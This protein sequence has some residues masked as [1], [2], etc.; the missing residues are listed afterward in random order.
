M[1]Q[2]LTGFQRDILYVIAGLDEPYGLGIKQRLEEYYERDVNNGRLYP[3]LDTLVEKGLVE[4]GQR[5]RRTNF[6]TLTR[7]G[8]RELK[9]RKEWE[10]N[11]VDV[12]YGGVR[13]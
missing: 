4:K 8:R 2:E 11:Y 7:R 12:E 10:A 1:M 9:A 5:D 6:Y 13:A 3:N